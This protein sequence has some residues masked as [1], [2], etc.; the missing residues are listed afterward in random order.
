MIPAEGDRIVIFTT[1]GHNARDL[2]SIM[3]IVTTALHSFGYHAV[4]WRVAPAG[5]A[6][7]ARRLLEGG[8]ANDDTE[9][10]D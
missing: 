10:P 2:P 4:H 1:V 6:R 7:E 5:A 8:D 9:N 3:R